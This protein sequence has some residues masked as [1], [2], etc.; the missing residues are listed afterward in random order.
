MTPI[1]DTRRIQFAAVGLAFAMF[2]AID[3]LILFLTPGQERG[4]ALLPPILSG[5]V[6]IAVLP[7]LLSL[8]EQQ[9]AR[10]ERQATEIETLHA[11][12]AAIFSEMELPRLLP[13]AADKSLVAC[14]AEASGIVVFDPV[15]RKLANESYRM[16][17]IAGEKE[18]A[19][20]TSLV[21]GGNAGG[22]DE[23]ETLAAPLMR[24][25]VGSADQTT[26]YLLVARRRVNNRPFGNSDRR[27]LD[28]LAGT[29]RI[30]VTNA[31]AL[32][33]ARE[34]QA[35]REELKV[36][37]ERQRRDQALTRAMTE[38]LLPE[39]PKRVGAW[40][41][42]QR[43]E[44]QSDEAPVGGDLYDLF[45]IAPGKWGVFIADVSGKGLAAARR[46][47]LV[48]YALRSYARE[49]FS[50]AKVLDHL[51]ET[52]F[53]EPELTGFV[54]L[55]YAILDEQAREVVWASAGH[56]APILRR[57]NGDFEA[58]HSTGT[59][60]GAIHDLTYTENRSVFHAGDGLLL[61]TD[62]LSEARAAGQRKQMME[63]E[64]IEREL[65]IIFSTPE[66][67]I[68]PVSVADAMM[69]ALHRFTGG[70]LSD[71]TAVVWMRYMPE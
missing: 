57:T 27:L 10:I 67:T 58:L 60:L 5:V 1:R 18:Q 45:Q 32:V 44:A 8:F 14:D 21:R 3:L 59:V 36:T 48:K 62:G 51:N 49:H 65:A 16:P 31:Y 64:G 35:V 23:W 47:A 52:L 2:G 12:D 30:A 19:R 66:N 4:A 55:F 37:K 43:Y 61:F 56:E 15:T 46:I 7:F 54:T 40:E 41:F 28:A 68:E 70:K 39:I 33:A 50:P 9:Q 13:V 38:G 53:D 25:H 29:V 26:G 63:V 69:T 24:A 11:M 71:D 20:F 42:S 17:D 34:A 6:V 22:D